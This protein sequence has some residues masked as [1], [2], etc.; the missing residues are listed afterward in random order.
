MLFDTL[1][2]LPINDPIFY[3]AA[4]PAVFVLGFAK[5]GF[6]GIGVLAMP[7]MVLVVSPLRAASIMLPVLIVQDAVSL[8]FYRHSFDR[9]TLVIM[10][11]GAC[12]GIALGY[13]FAAYLPDAAIE[14]AVGVI[15]GAFAARR[16]TLSP[17]AAATP[18]IGHPLLGTFW[19]GVSGFTS[20]IANAGMPPFQVYVIPQ[21]L[22]RDVLVGTG[23]VFFAVINWTKVVP[24]YALGQLTPQNLATSTVLLPVAVI[25]TW[26]GVWLVRRIPAERFY[27]IIYVIMIS[28]SVKLIWDGVRGL[29]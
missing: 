1:F 7:I 22:P 29:I 23:I 12:G 26:M 5:G 18:K 16:L 17:A 15:A 3:L 10:L 27:K 6:A 24:F 14:L 2:D 20:M 11:P 4:I 25:S 13:A 8:W 19:G 21:L 9:R 28:L